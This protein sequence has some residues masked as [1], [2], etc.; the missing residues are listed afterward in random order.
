MTAK[1]DEMVKM[2]LPKDNETILASK[3]ELYLPSKEALQEEVKKL[4]EAQQ[5]FDEAKDGAEK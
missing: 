3:Y 1:N 4:A 5:K 2:T